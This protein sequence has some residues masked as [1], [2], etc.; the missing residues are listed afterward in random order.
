M[1]LKTHFG[2][3]KKSPFAFPLSSYVITLWLWNLI[4]LIFVNA[5]NKYFEVHRLCQSFDVLR[6]VNWDCPPPRR[7]STWV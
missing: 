4:L 7:F 6:S 1:P 3:V 5:I 2:K